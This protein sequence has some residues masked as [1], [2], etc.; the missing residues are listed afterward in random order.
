MRRLPFSVATALAIAIAT[1]AIPAR[2]D[3]SDDSKPTI[4]LAAPSNLD[5]AVHNAQIERAAG[6]LSDATKSLSQLMLVAP[7]DARVVGEYGKLLVQEGQPQDGVQFLHRAIELSSSDWTLF[8][9]LGV[10]YDEM[11]DAGNAGLAYRHALALKPGEPAILNNI[12]LSR[13]A[14]G[15]LKGAHEMLVAAQAAGGTDSEIVQNLAR[16]E[17]KMPVAKVTAAVPVAAKPVTATPVAATPAP[18]A[19]HAAAT[20]MTAPKPAAVEVAALPNAKQPV[21]AS[22]APRNIVMQTVPKDPLAG[23]TAAKKWTKHHVAVAHPVATTTSAAVAAPAKPVV[24]VKPAAP[25]VK[26]ASVAA[27]HKSN[28]T[29]TL[30]MSADAS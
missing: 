15:D 1:T 3:D 11:G 6:K 25:V 7:D 13:L 27:E 10:A 8:S 4:N 5:Q 2:A 30:R 20:A 17:A 12:A 22:G 21:E 23:P 18:I 28:K 16:V 26:P 24:A 19:T 29:P 14:I 9:A